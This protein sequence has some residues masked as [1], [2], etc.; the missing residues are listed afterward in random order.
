MRKLRHL[1]IAAAIGV[2]AGGS[3]AA[4]AQ[5]DAIPGPGPRLA[6]RPGIHDTTRQR[7]RLAGPAASAPGERLKRLADRLGLSEDQRA[8]I[9]KLWADG[10]RDQLAARKDLMRLRN[11]LRGEMLKDN[12]DA[13]RVEG[14]SQRIGELEARMHTNRLMMR[15]EVRKL[16]TPEQ[17]DRLL[18]MR[19]RHGFGRGQGDRAGRWG[20]GWRHRG[21][22]FGGYGPDE[23]I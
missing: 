14:L 15:L 7:D 1:L 13:R 12:P 22:D 4:L 16:L 5:A 2:V 11:D 3:T 21:G 20:P 19:E 6:T 17:R 23:E 9:R 10:E 8:K 18:L